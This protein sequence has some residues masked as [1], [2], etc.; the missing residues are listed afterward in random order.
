[1]TKWRDTR[2]VSS[3]VMNSRWPAIAT[4]SAYVPRALVRWGGR[5]G[6]DVRVVGVDLHATTARAALAQTPAV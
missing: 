5:R 1:M 4:G 6:F 3:R 2:P